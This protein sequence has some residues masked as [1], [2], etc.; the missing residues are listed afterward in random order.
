[1]ELST[2]LVEVETL[3]AN[4]FAGR[5][6]LELY[7][8]V[9]YTFGVKGK[10]MRPTLVMLGNAVCGGNPNEALAPA[11]A[12]EMFH[13]F[14]LL[15]DD[16]M[17]K[18]PLRRNLATVWE[19]FGSNPAI[20]SGDVM[21]V[22]GYSIL[23]KSSKFAEL[24]VVF[25]KAAV[26][27][28]EGQQL[29]MNFENRDDVS[30][31]EYMKMIELKTS[32]LLAACLQLGA[33]TAGASTE[34]QQKLYTAGLNL[35]IGFQLHDDILDV[36]GD[37]QKFGKQIGGDIIANKKTFLLIKT[38]E[39]AQ[40]DLLDDLMYHINAAHFEPE[41]KVK[42]VKDIYNKLSIKDLAER[43]MNEYFNLGL[44][45]IKAIDLPSERKEEL[46]SFFNTLIHRE[47]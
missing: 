25:S 1:M 6:P 27:V 37:P 43:K 31:D 34:L 13:N 21:L 30:I 32:V 33:I 24:A 11:A 41:E 12:V 23:S 8:P 15:H 39:L 17:D 2:F 22:L 16:I 20:L 40:G 44:T 42:A 19:K 35:G 5:E 7:A 45:Q 26:E 36:F 4:S 46:L 29:D 28:C 3:I 38:F 14:T 47:K 18:A 10:R 9:S